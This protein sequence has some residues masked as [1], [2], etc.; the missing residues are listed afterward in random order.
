MWLHNPRALLF[1]ALLLDWLGQLFIFLGLLVSHDW[2]TSQ[3]SQFEV[4]AP[5]LVFCLVLY[6]L[7]GWLL[8]S[9]TVLRWHRLSFLVLFQ[10]LLLTSLVTL[11]IVSIAC[12]I[13]NPGDELWIVT[14]SVQCFWLG[15]SL[16]GH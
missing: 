7:F 12:W 11:T 8:G 9:Y 5:W 2:L 16:F 13:I 4:Q 10:R 6:P 1:S 15:T 14:G 3:P